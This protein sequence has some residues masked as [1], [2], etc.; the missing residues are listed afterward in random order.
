MKKFWQNNTYKVILFAGLVLLAV[1]NIS[2][3]GTGL[4]KV[5]GI[6]GPV[7]MGCFLAY[8][9]NILLRP[10]EKR[11]VSRFI[12]DEHKTAKRGVSMVISIAIILILIGLLLRIVIPQFIDSM[13]V[14]IKSLPAMIEKIRTV[15]E[16]YMDMMPGQEGE[17]VLNK[18]NPEKITKNL[19][20]IFNYLTTTGGKAVKSVFG[21]GFDL[22]MG[23]ILA[24]YM[25]AS[26]EMLKRQF[27]A[28]YRR[29]FSQ[30]R[31]KKILYVLSV[32]DNSFHSFIVGQTIEAGILGVLCVVGLLIFR[33]PFA[34]M[35][36]TVI[37]VTAL[38]PML[39]AYIGGAFGF[40]VIFTQDPVKALLFLVFLV[41]IQQFEG[42][43][44]YPK[45]VGTSVG[46]PGFW[47]FLAVI[48]GGGFFG[49][50]GVFFSVPLASA[51]YKML[52]DSIHNT[53]SLNS[54]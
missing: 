52:G 20:A 8:V 31:E 18:L 9:L 27:I 12:S 50:L 37:G 32:L 45:V 44:I 30:E 26:K 4:G 22:V 2:A 16:R 49:V 7:F 40:L 34:V 42:N 53:E 25:V 19:E 48:I 41:I 10:I 23:L 46:L 39:G 47:V 11:L 15:S 24:I 6:L 5:L 13:T 3:I 21:F 43:V 17:A 35:I 54:N 29:F 33:F 1:I 14:F 28:L 51:V 38:V 36:G